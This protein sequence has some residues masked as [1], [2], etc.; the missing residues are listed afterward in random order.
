MKLFKTK[1]NEN[2]Y[3]CSSLITDISPFLHL[4]IRCNE[5]EIDPF[6]TYYDENDT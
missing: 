4:D 5:M 2:A 6:I 1:I 3:I